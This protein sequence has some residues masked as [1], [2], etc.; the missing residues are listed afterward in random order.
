MDILIVTQTRTPNGIVSFNCENAHLFDKVETFKCITPFDL[1]ILV[2]RYKLSNIRKRLSPIGF[3][4]MSGVNKSV[5][6]VWFHGEY[7]SD[8]IKLNRILTINKII[9]NDNI[10]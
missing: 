2:D 8:Y 9:K 6:H 10:S 5:V 1:D 7:T 4:T 3:L